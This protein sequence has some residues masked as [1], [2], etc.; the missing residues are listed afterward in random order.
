MA[1][2]APT[3]LP[4]IAGQAL[5]EIDRLRR[6]KAEAEEVLAE[7]DEVW[8]EAGRPGPLGGSKAQNTL[9]VIREAVL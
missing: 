9:A 6:W 2:Y 5:D 4:G 1:R 7:W 8:E 3:S